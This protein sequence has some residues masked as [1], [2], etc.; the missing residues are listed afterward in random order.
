M[1]AFGDFD[2]AEFEAFAQRV[3]SQVSGGQLKSEVKNSVR[4]VGETY[5]RNAESRTPVQSGEL[6]RSWQLKGPFF[7]GSDI[8]VELK[9]G[10]N[11]A[12]F[13][14]NGHRQTPGRYVPAIGKKLK[15]SWVPGQHF[16]Q[17]A[18]DETRGQVPQLLTPVMDDILRRL[19]D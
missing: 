5:K 17:K 15:A 6:R 16:L 7:A 14:E 1:S 18:T 3:N 8:T 13:V 4:N 2:N 19:M 9:N 10:K 11:Y 12:S